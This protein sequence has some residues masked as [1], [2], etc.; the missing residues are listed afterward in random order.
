MCREKEK[1]SVCVEIE[2]ACKDSEWE[3][4]SVCVCVAIEIGSV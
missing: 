4:E 2:S 3:P 1:G